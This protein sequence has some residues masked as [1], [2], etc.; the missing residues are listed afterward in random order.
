MKTYGAPIHSGRVTNQH[1]LHALST[2][3][4]A[5]R[6][7]SKQERNRFPELESSMA[8]NQEGFAWHPTTIL[9]N[10]LDYNALLDFH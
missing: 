5:E 1:A 2:P 9:K 4:R 3:M 7:S 8:A 6:M 10:T